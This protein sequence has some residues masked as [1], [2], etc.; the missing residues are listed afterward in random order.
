VR[1]V[2]VFVVAVIAGAI[3]SVAGGGTL[4]TFPTLVW[5][6]VPPLPA[7]MT[8]SVALW[9]GQI[10]SVWGYRR[11][12]AEVERRVLA[13]VVPSIIGGVIGGVLLILTPTRVFDRVVPFLILFATT[14]FTAQRAIQRKFDLTAIHHTSEHWLTWTMIFQFIVALYGGYFGAGMGILMLAALSLMGHTDIH[15]MNALKNLLATCMNGASAIYFAL[16]AD[17]VWLDAFVMAIGSM[18]GGTAGAGLAIRLDPRVVRGIVIV[19]G[20]GSAL[21]LLIRGW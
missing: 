12:L 11:Q 2:L 3:N 19:V 18:I 13:L 1:V 10:S 9:P 16:T 21:A 5:L 14:L 7:N 17:V 6:G 20:F 4:L 15:R 8:N